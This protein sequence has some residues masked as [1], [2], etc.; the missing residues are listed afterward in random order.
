MMPIGRYFTVVGSLLAIGL[1]F[2][3]GNVEPAPSLPESSLGNTL[4]SMANRSDRS[5]VISVGE[6]TS[7]PIRSDKSPDGM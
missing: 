3:A 7:L 1:W 4:R 2:M 6:V 5:G